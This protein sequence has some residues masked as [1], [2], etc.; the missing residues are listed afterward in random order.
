V[1]RPLR[2][3]VPG[4]RGML[5]SALV[6]RLAR[7]PVEILVATR[8]ELDLLDAAAVSEWTSRERPDW[9]MIAAARVGG[10]LANRDHPGEFIRENLAIASNIIHAAYEAGV[11]KLVHVA[12]SAIYPR[13]A[14]QPIAEDA[15]M[16]GT[17]DAEHVPYSVAKIAGITMCSAYRRQYGCDF[18]SAVPTNL[19]GPGDNFD[20]I[21]SHVVPA[22]IRKVDAAKHAKSPE[23]VV[24]GTGNPRREFLH[25]DD[26]ADALFFLMGNYSGET[27]INIG[28]GDDVTIL[29]LT[30]LVCD[31]VG[32]DGA[33][34][35]D[36]A[37]PDGT[38]RKLLDSTR[39]QALG[40]GPSIELRQGLEETYKWYRAQA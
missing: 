22:I 25:V 4:H 33:I 17:I 26:L 24:W 31:V 40:W 9:V 6:R 7:E 37:K 11:A 15:L 14:A 10:I 23:I 27:H 13:E 21:S 20:P 19:Y 5:G 3:W 18:I 28:Y 30:R 29:E 12:S 35:H 36:L 38:A 1:S 2:V 39:L 8:E 32:Y 16:T 34:V